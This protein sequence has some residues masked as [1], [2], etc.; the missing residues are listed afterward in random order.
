MIHKPGAYLLGCLWL[1]VLALSLG[2]S[3]LTTERR[4]REVE[5]YAA[6]CDPFGYL[7]IAQDTR[8]AAAAGRLPNF[9]IESNHARLLIEMM[10]SRAVPVSHWDDLV[11]PLCYHY[12]PRADHIGVQYPPGAGLML[13][14]FPQG[15]ALHSLDRV[16]IL[17]FAVTGL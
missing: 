4:A 13:A 15:E 7:Q 5:E 2:V 14:I 11:A 16:V 8:Q 17:L 10:K 12:S 3:A 9:S 1:C 6:L